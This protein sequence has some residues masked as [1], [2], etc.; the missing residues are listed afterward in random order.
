V[1]ALLDASG[2]HLLIFSNAAYAGDPLDGSIDRTR[3][4]FFEVVEMGDYGPAKDAKP[5][6]IAE[7]VPLD[8][9][10]VQAD[11]GAEA[12]PGTGGLFGRMILINVGD[13]TEFSS[14]ATALSNFNTARSLW[15]AADA[16]GPTL[17]DADPPVSIVHTADLGTIR[18]QWAQPIDAVSAMLMRESISNEFVV[19]AGLRAIT[20]WVVTMPTKYYYVGL[21]VAPTRLFQSPLRLNGACDVAGAILYNRESGSSYS[22]VIFDVP[23]PLQ[24]LCWAST[25]ISFS[26]LAQGQAQTGT[27]FG[28]KNPSAIT[29]Y[30]WDPANATPSF[31]GTT[32]EDG[33]MTIALYGSSAHLLVGGA[34]T[35]FKPDGSTETRPQATYY[36][37]PVIGFA[38]ESY[39]NGTLTVNGQA[40][41]SNYGGLIGHRYTRNVQ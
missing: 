24:A 27:L 30:P 19:S 23:P 37:L 25:V 18:T 10:R 21:G 38:A 15:A 9:S 1:P 16:P 8:C 5:G 34:T 17:A 36:G 31:V 6:S 39:T 4:G 12:Q 35:V 41:L 29:P 33:W 2:Q 11:T 22:P 26:Y 28:S 3:E 20:D 13:G 14:T 32:F 40:V 7:G